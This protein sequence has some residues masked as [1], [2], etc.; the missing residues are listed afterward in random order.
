MPADYSRAIEILLQIMGEE[1]P[2][3][4]GM[5]T[6]FYWLMPVGKF[7]ELSGLEHFDLSIHAIAEL[8]K[9]NTGEYTVRPFIRKYPKK[10]FAVMQDWARSE[11]FHL[12]RLASE[13]LRPK[14]PWA[15]KLELFVENPEPVFAI[16]EILKND[17]KKF[18]MKSVANNMADY[19]KLNPEPALQLLDTWEQGAS[20]RTKW[21]IKHAK[22][23]YTP[24]TEE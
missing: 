5:F 13:G 24:K 12:R 8:T 14:L 2:H 6:N 1:N 23:K 4:T 11:N 16:L 15:S 10:M 21:I 19:L 7:I 18:V 9:R 20:D 17:E 22:R 3:E